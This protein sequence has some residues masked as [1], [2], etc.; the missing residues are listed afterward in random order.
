MSIIGVLA[1]QGAFEKHAEAVRSAGGEARLVKLPPDLGALDGLII[2]GGESTVIGKLMRKNGLT[3]AIRDAAASGLPIF[4][5][6]AGLIMLANEVEGP[7]VDG[8]R[9]MNI[10]VERNGYGRQRESFRSPVELCEDALCR[11]GDKTES[12][13]PGS[14]FIRA[15]RILET[16]EGVAVLARREGEPVLVREGRLLGCAF[17]PEL[18]GDNRV[19]R[20]FLENIC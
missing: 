18:T 17:H 2:P 4:G 19:H 5:T 1:L 14:L 16:G 8:L 11:P 20:Y 13:L 10:R 6:C 15:P 9:L 12:N 7:R 3:G